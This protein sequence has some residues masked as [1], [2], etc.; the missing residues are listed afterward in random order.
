VLATGHED[1]VCVWDIRSS[2]QHMSVLA[3][4]QSRVLAVDW[5]PLDREKLLSVSAQQGSRAASSGSI[6]VWDLNSPQ[7]V[8]DSIDIENGMPG[9]ARFLPFG[10][11]ILAAV[12]TTVV[13]FSLDGG[14]GRKA[15]VV[16]S[17]NEHTAPVSFVGF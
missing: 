12:D 1:T 17:F 4:G 6:K 10:P 8:H 9:A 14:S 7:K 3:P 16:E 11:A 5:S 2:S 13:V 15:K